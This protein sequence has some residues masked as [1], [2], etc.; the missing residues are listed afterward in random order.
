MGTEELRENLL[1][2]KLNKISVVRATQERTGILYNEQRALNS[3]RAVLQSFGKLFEHAGVEYLIAV[4]V[5][6]KAEPVAVQ[7]VGMGGLHSAVVNIPDI[8]RFVML[9]NC[10]ELI[11]LHNHPSGN[12]MASYED[13]HVTEKLKKACELLDMKL[14]DHVIVGEDGMG[15]SCMGECMVYAEEVKGA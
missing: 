6:Q 7:L 13:V 1:V 2:Q 10:N 14:L 3:P 11:L 15:Y 5:N 8:L 9:A 4:A 12:P